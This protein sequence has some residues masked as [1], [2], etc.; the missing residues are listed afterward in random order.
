MRRLSSSLLAVAVL[1]LGMLCA[2]RADGSLSHGFN[3]NIDWKSFDEGMELSK[4][5][6]KPMLL[7][8]HKSWCGTCMRA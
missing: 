1:L 3:D 5:L 4:S 8:I 6:G 2:S 7:L